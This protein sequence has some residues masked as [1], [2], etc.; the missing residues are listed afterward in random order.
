MKL[1]IVIEEITDHETYVL[2]YEVG[3]K[4]LNGAAVKCAMRRIGCIIPHNCRGRKALSLKGDVWFCFRNDNFLAGLENGS[5]DQY[6][7]S[8]KK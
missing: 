3:S 1:Y 2:G 5:C 4:N 8:R 7:S 6:L